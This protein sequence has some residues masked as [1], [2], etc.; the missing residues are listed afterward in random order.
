MQQRQTLIIGAPKSGISLLQSILNCSPHTY[1]H[2]GIEFQTILN[3]IEHI[4]KCEKII[5]SIP[6]ESD[7]NVYALSL[8]VEILQRLGNKLLDGLNILR[9]MSKVNFVWLV[10]DPIVSAA[11]YLN[12]GVKPAEAL[13]YWY[14]VNGCLWHFYASLPEK[15][16]YLI[17]YEE[18]VL[19]ISATKR[20][21]EFLGLQYNKQYRRYGDFDH[22][23]EFLKETIKKRRI[24]YETVDPYPKIDLQDYWIKYRNSSLIGFLDY[25]NPAFD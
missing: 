9:W 5:V 4:S 8:S 6:M 7:V 13:W 23:T 24:D 11:H 21:F 1:I 20:L 18:I 17:K 14:L 15:R 22:P 19:S 16:R 2:A 25:P 10:R 3:N 12:Y